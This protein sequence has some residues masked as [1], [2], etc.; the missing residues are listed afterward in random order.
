MRRKNLSGYASCRYATSS[1]QDGVPIL[2]YI[3]AVVI[4]WEPVLLVVAALA[5]VSGADKLQHG[6]SV[7]RRLSS[8]RIGLLSGCETTVN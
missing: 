8:W 7:A 1:G 5:S 3:S 4:I 2:N 6:F